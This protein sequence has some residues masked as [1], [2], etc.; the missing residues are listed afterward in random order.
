MDYLD[1]IQ[2]FELEVTNKDIIIDDLINVLANNNP[3]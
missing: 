1:R 3:E 2:E